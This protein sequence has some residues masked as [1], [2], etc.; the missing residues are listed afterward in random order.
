MIETAP[1]H[2]GLNTH[3][4]TVSGRRTPIRS[5]FSTAN[6]TLTSPCRSIYFLQQHTALTSGCDSKGGST[7]SIVSHRKSS[8]HMGSL[9][10][11]HVRFYNALSALREDTHFMRGMQET[12]TTSTSDVFQIFWI[13]DGGRAKVSCFLFV[14][15][16]EPHPWVTDTRNSATK[17][18]PVATVRGDIHHLSANTKHIIK[19]RLRLRCCEICF[20]TDQQA[21]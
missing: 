3:R 14:L 19:G 11:H 5:Y 1:P 7:H 2:R 9:A 8:Y 6:A 17:R 12:K 13:S 10:L 16:P 21:Q 15:P 18:S 4:R 20:L